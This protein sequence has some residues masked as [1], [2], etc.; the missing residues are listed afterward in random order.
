MKMYSIDFT[1]SFLHKKFILIVLYD[2]LIQD[3]FCVLKDRE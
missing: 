2:C 1:Q 3:T